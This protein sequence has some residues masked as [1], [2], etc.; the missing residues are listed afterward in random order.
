MFLNRRNIVNV[1]ISRAKD[2]LI[3]LIPDKETD[4][5]WNLVELGRLLDIIR[6]DLKGDYWE[7][8]SAEIE[9][10]LFKQSN[11]LEINTF[12]TT[13]QNINVYTEPEK[14][15]EIRVEEMAIDVQIKRNGQLIIDN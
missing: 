13:H 12:A 14:Q 9:E 3:L 8:S 7:K 6:K 1:A 4:K 5:V 10:L 2:Y 15:F 11:Y